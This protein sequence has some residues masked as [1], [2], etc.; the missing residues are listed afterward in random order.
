M[1]EE[2]FLINNFCWNFY[3]KKITDISANF[4]QCTIFVQTSSRSQPLTL[5]CKLLTQL[6][7]SSLFPLFF[8][9]LKVKKLLVQQYV[10]IRPLFLDPPVAI[11]SSQPCRKS[12]WSVA[13]FSARAADQ[14]PLWRLGAPPTADQSQGCIRSASARG[15]RPAAVSPKRSGSRGRTSLPVPGSPCAAGPGTG[16]RGRPPKIRPVELERSAGSRPGERSTRSRQNRTHMQD[17]MTTSLGTRSKI[18][19]VRCK[20]YIMA[21]STYIPR[22]PHCLSHRPNWNPPTNLFSKRVCPPPPRN[23][24]GE[25]HTRLR[26]RGWGVPIRTTGEKA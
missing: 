5:F 2:P 22:A 8:F 11:S 12:L 14:T 4:Y 20:R 7:V 13:A 17:K 10:C 26:L 25:E 9:L 15:W 3:I 21:K 16:R 23:Q 1:K 6:Q 24:R 19:F 18:V